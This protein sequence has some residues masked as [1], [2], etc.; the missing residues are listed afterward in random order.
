MNIPQISVIVPVYNVE[1]YLSRCIESILSQTFTDFELL[2]IDDGSTD[3]SGE[4]CD[5]YAKKDA[6]IR[7][8]HKENGG[9]ASAR[10]MGIDKAMGKYSIHADGDDWAESK[11]LEKM[12][13]RIIET[14]ADMVIADY[15]H[16]NNGQSIYIQQRNSNKIF[17]LDILNEILVG[18][19][20]GSLWN[21]LIRHS[22]YQD[23]NIKFIQN[24]NFC[25][26]VLILIRLLLLNI[27]VTFLHK[28][29]YHYC[30]QNTNSITKN[31]TINSFR[32]QQQYVEELKKFLPNKYNNTI[33]IVAFQIKTG[34]FYHNV[35]TKKEFY[36]YMPTSL[37]TILLGKC[38]KKWKL[39]M[40]LSY[41]GIYCWT[42]KIWCNY[43]KYKNRT[44]VFKAV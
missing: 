18:Y 13:L 11:M 12:F 38:A 15:F 25:E 26:D 41:L 33:E 8:L 27:K 34:A 36:D 44:N 9:V 20:S 19:L 43:K 5:E 35:L 10:Q 21:K 3:R 22:L 23:Y 28:A 30:S 42:K 40:L 16:D 24:I 29:F 14:N 37:Q 2:L 7:V 6:R 32:M 4:I 39:R 1:K 31:Y 17:S